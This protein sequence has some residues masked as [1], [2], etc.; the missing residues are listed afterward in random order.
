MSGSGH[1]PAESAPRASLR[2]SSPSI[3]FSSSCGAMPLFSILRTA[4]ANILAPCLALFSRRQR[5]RRCACGPGSH[6]QRQVKWPLLP[7]IF[8]TKPQLLLAELLL[9]A[10]LCF[11]AAAQIFPRSIELAR[12]G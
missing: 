4:E 1:T 2:R 11:H 12:D 6:A 7:R 8:V 5:P 10:Q 9:S 3:A